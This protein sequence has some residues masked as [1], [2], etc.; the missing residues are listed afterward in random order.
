MTTK[1]FYPIKLLE[2][3]VVGKHLKLK[4]CE[5]FSRN[6]ENLEIPELFVFAVFNPIFHYFKASKF[7][8]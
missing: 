7:E 5:I 4:V 6:I 8:F 3:K 2:K 1:N